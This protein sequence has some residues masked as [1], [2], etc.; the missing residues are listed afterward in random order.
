MPF[1]RRARPFLCFTKIPLLIISFASKDIRYD[2]F[3]QILIY[4]AGILIELK[5]KNNRNHFVLV[6]L[7]SIGNIFIR[8]E[9]F[10]RH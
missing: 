1:N 2:I 10:F 3:I 7:S 4:T 9:E 8:D 6:L 5:V